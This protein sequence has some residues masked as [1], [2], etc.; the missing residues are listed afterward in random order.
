MSI[1]NSMKKQGE[2]TRESILETGLKLWPNVTPT[3]IANTLNISHGTVIYHFPD[4]KNAVAE[5]AV[6]TG[7][8]RVIVQLL[9]MRHKAVKDMNAVEHIKHFTAI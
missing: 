2:Q 4:I 9:A 3:S 5:Y 1:T 8:S 7:N 6:K